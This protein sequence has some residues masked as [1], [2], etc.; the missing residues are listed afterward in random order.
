MSQSVSWVDLI[1]DPPTV[2]PPHTSGNEPDFSGFLNSPSPAGPPPAFASGAGPQE[3]GN[4]TNLNKL[5]SSAKYDLRV[6]TPYTSNNMFD[7]TAVE[8]APPALAIG[9]GAV[10]SGTATSPASAGGSAPPTGELSL[11]NP[12]APEFHPGGQA[13]SPH[14]RRTPPLSLS[15][16]EKKKRKRDRYKANKRLARDLAS[17]NITAGDESGSS[18]PGPSSKRSKPNNPPERPSAPTAQPVRG[19]SSSGRRATYSETVGTRPLVIS[20]RESGRSLGRPDLLKLEGLVQENMTSDKPGFPVRNL[21][22]FLVAEPLGSA[23]W[24][25]DPMTL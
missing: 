2:D 1:E 18:V 17:V 12:D 7:G 14:E 9:G 6:Y 21:A 24:T 15:L 13:S 20:S 5:A 3:S 22:L 11:L 25:R 10:A 8:A 4:D 19:A 23:A 16:H